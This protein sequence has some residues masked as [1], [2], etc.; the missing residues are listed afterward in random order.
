MKERLN[1]RSMMRKIMQ[2]GNMG[3]AMVPI[4]LWCGAMMLHHGWSKVSDNPQEFVA[5]VHTDLYLP[6]FLGWAAI[7]GEFL[8][9]FLVLIGLWTRIGAL[10]VLCTM[11]VAGFVAHKDD[12]WSKKEHA[13]GYAVLAFSVLIAGGGMA[14]ID[15]RLSRRMS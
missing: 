14:S 5:W 13:V 4:R 6:E 9:G 15:E 8:G 2:T 7:G 10:F 12:P 1:M 3:L 11:L